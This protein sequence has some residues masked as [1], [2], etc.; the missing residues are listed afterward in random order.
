MYNWMHM[1]KS[2]SRPVVHGFMVLEY[3]D[4]SVCGGEG[5]KLSN[6]MPA[7]FPPACFPDLDNKLG[8][9]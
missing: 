8:P 2:L 1:K 5:V 7:C 4:H 9:K 3:F 6:W